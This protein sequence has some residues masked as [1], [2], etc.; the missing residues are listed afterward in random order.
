VNAKHRLAWV[1]DRARS[2]W[3]PRLARIRHAWT[4]IEIE[5]VRSGLRRCAL[6]IVPAFRVFE[7]MARLAPDG[8]VARSVQSLP[9]SI[10][11]GSETGLYLRIA[12]GSPPDAGDLAGAFSAR[13]DDAVG[14][15][16]GYPDCCIASFRRSWVDHGETDSTFAAAT[17]SARAAGGDEA[18][19]SVESAPETNLL[20]RWLGVRLVP[21]LVCR[22]DCQA[23]LRSGRAFASLGTDLGFA[24]EMEWAAQML[25]WPVEWSALHGIAEVRTPIVKIMTP[26]DVTDRKQIVRVKGASYP[27]EGARG[28]TF[29]YS[30]AS[31]M[32]HDADLHEDNGFVS[33]AAMHAIHAPLVELAAQVVLD[34]A[35]AVLDLGCGNGLLVDKICRISNA[36]P[37]GIDLDPDKCRRAQRLHPSGTWKCGDVFSE[38]SIWFRP[39]RLVLLSAARLAEATADQRAALLSSIQ[40]TAEYLLVYAYPGTILDD[41][42]LTENH[43]VIERNEA[44]VLFQLLSNCSTAA[45]G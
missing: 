19:L 6:P 45:V 24:D 4:E 3:E 32:P 35:H 33:A 11:T 17:A 7:L 28:V 22:F 34:P 20:L 13:D 31:A 15:L 42:T 16:L 18:T 41:P 44:A 40:A 2:V 29:P 38:R 12:A 36:M 1:S 5:S 8:L 43:L 26:T 9:A 25:S 10:V 23:S 27:R 37:F 39:Y 14:R 21:H 30:L